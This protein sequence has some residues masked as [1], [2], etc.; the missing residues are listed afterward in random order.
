MLSTEGAR[1]IVKVKQVNNLSIHTNDWGTYCVRAPDG[2]CL[3]E[4]SRLEDAIAWAE[5]TKDFV[6]R[7]PREGRA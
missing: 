2:K 3:E 6:R 7:K 5:K 1:G 4:F